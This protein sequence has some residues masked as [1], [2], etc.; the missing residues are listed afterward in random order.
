MR[1]FY[2]LPTSLL[3][4]SLRIIWVV[5]SLLLKAFF[6]FQEFRWLHLL[7]S[8]SGKLFIH[9]SCDNPHKKRLRSIRNETEEAAKLLNMDFELV[10]IRKDFSQI[11]VYYGD[12]QDEPVPIYCDDGKATNLREI[13]ETLRNMV[14]VLSF[15]PKY[16]RLKQLRREIMRPS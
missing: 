14:F 8:N 5:L 13:C 12:G 7:K 4:I 16:S 9:A 10:K 11:Y 3:L 2:L 15:H 6:S 1:L